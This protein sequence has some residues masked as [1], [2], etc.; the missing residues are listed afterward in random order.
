MDACLKCQ[1]SFDNS[2][3]SMSDRP[4]NMDTWQLATL[5]LSLELRCDL[6]VRMP[7][8][9]GAVF[10]GTLQDGLPSSPLPVSLQMLAVVATRWVEGCRFAKYSVW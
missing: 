8:V 10:C 3:L 9:F 7:L 6:S 2:L 1:C 5:V 4:E